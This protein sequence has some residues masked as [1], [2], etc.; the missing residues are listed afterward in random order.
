MMQSIASS[1][2]GALATKQSRFL[3]NRLLRFARN[4]GAMTAKTLL[5]VLLIFG[6]MSLPSF[7]VLSNS[8]ADAS[9]A[10]ATWKKFLDQ[11]I[12]LGQ[13]LGILAFLAR[14]QGGRQ[15]FAH[16]LAHLGLLRI[17][18]RGGQEGDHRQA[19]D[20]GE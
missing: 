1:L 10:Q 5:R 17:R 2:R 6:L 18:G 16:L 15:R 14:F 19:R 4:D 13:G 20:H 9:A 8:F 11:G 12:E 7:F 3:K